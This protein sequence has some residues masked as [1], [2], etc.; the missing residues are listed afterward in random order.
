M[1]VFSHLWVRLTLMTS[2]MTVFCVL[3]MLATIIV[4]EIVIEANF[5][6]NL[7]VEILTELET[8]EAS[9]PIDEERLAEIYASYDTYHIIT[10]TRV[11]TTLGVG[12]GLAILVVIFA[13]M[14]LAK[15]ATKPISDV[16]RAAGDIVLGDL[17]VRVDGGRKIGG[18]EIAGLVRNFNRMAESLELS[19]KRVREDMAA[20]AHELRTPLTI[21]SG[22]LQGI[23][24]GVFPANT[25]ELERLL[26]QTQMLAVLIEDLRTVSLGKAG[27][28]NLLCANVDLSLLADAA[29]AAVEPRFAEQGMRVSKQL[30]RAPVNG[31]ENRLLQVITNLLE[32]A[33]RYA[34]SGRCVE[35][36]SGT[37]E[38]VAFFEVHDRGPG[39]PESEISSI[40]EAFRRGEASRSRA[41]GGSGLGLAVVATLVKAH[42]GHVTAMN[43]AGG[44]ACFRVELPLLETRH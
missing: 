43:R 37:N 20:I 2:L 13:A 36:E 42:D 23:R 29:I 6:A 12:G 35:I 11:I 3:F 10:W 15:M 33:A 16:A 7:P 5:R 24:D 34:A 30:E 27:E 1:R 32:N 26:K 9:E 31:D 40:F 19:E 4:F 8:I 25:E 22:R 38:N 44:G 28:I 17:S 18:A 39:L 41:T 14:A 21:L